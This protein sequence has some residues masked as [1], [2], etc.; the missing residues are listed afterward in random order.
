MVVESVDGDDEIEVLPP[1]DRMTGGNRATL[2]RM[3]ARCLGTGA[4]PLS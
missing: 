4:R 3:R 1:L 2:E